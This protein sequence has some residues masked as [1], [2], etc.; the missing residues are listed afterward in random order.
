MFLSMATSLA[1]ALL[2]SAA[3]CSKASGSP[4]F[5][6]AL[7]G[8]ETGKGRRETKGRRMGAQRD[9]HTSQIVRKRRRREKERASRA[10][11]S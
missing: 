4:E 5:E 8:G 6:S 2:I 3:A 11:A 1:A 10:L 9:T 7:Q